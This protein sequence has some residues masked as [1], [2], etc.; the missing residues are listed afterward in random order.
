MSGDADRL[1]QAIAKLLARA[2]RTTPA[3]GLVRVSV[4]RRDDRIA[5]VVADTGDG[6]AP[7]ELKHVFAPSLGRSATRPSG[8]GLGFDLALVRAV[9]HAHD[10]TVGAD[11]PGRGEGLTFTL[12]LPA[13][14]V[15]SSER[16]AAIG[17]DRSLEGIRVLAVETSRTGASSCGACSRRRRR[18]TR[19]LV[20]RGRDSALAREWWPD[21]LLTD[22]AMPV[23]DGYAVLDALR[24]RQSREPLRAL[25]MT[26]H[27]G[28]QE[29]GRTAD[30][31]F[32]AHLAKPVAPHEI[33]DA[34]L[35]ASPA[36]GSG[37][38]GACRLSDAPGWGS[39]SWPGSCS[40]R[41]R[42][43]WP[44]DGGPR[45]TRRTRPGRWRRLPTAAA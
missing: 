43:G 44:S 9:A 14:V 21:V 25:A 5:I 11:S 33:V 18:G 28:P 12:S 15:S 35:G 1:T 30:A 17:G 20:R 23:T 36:I 3:G 29:R 26:A 13:L 24:A 4:E 42:L 10:G 2:E 6:I 7:P 37:R 19:R 31:G 40:C 38:E 39:R 16:P 8:G 45:G 22:I 32:D 27:A 34:H 41:A